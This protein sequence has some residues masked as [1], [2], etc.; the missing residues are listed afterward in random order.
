MNN[1]TENYKHDCTYEFLFCTCYRYPLMNREGIAELLQ[2]KIKDMQSE[3]QFQLLS[4]R[5]WPD[6]VHL[7]VK[8]MPDV[9]PLECMKHI[10]Q[11]T[12]MEIKKTCPKII[13]SVPVI[14][15]RKGI[16]STKGITEEMIEEFREEQKRRQR[17]K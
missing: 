14:W 1:K 9:S 4:F 16:I 8:C 10:K 3:G 15:P 11:Q 12:A 6:A 2:K 13:N 17:S 5:T 7:K